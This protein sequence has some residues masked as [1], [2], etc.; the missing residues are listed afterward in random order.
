MRNNTGV[1]IAL[2]LLGYGIIR[3]G[4]GGALLAQTLEIIGTEIFKTP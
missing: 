2:L 4:V 1:F 3:I